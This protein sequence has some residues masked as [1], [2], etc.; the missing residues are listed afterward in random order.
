MKEEKLKPRLFFVDQDQNILDAL[1]RN[2]R[3]HRPIWDMH[4]IS[5]NRKVIE[6]MLE[7]PA[8]IIVIDSRGGGCA[9]FGILKDK[10]PETMRVLLSGG[11]ESELSVEVLRT[12]NQFLAKPCTTE[13]IQATL[14]DLLE[15]QGQLGSGQLRK[16]IM[17]LDSLPTIP[18]YYWELKKAVENPD[19]SASDIAALL[20]KDVAITAKVLQLANSSFFR[21]GRNYQ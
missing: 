12:A 10:F 13:E 6:L 17:K 5:N 19:S 21:K 8:N 11:T 14:A 18:D 7:A 15:I 2:F 20:S 9:L 4:F 3:S 16:K 1:K